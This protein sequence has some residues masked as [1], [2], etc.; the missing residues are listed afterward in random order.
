MNGVEKVFPMAET[1]VEGIADG[2]E[3]IRAQIKG[4]LLEL[5]RK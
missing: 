2:N 3:R 5:A 4:M 1:Y